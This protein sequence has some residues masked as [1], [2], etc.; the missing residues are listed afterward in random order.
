MAKVIRQRIITRAEVRANPDRYYVFGDNMTGTGY[1]GQAAQM[2]GEVNAV[3]V[4][5][6]WRPDNN[7]GSASDRTPP[8]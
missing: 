1:G 3:G 2:R 8:R 5:T 4:P 6:K 7:E